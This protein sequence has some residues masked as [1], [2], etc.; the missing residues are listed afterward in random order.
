VRVTFWEDLSI[1]ASCPHDLWADD[2]P[3]AFGDR[4]CARCETKVRVVLTAAAFK[5]TANHVVPGTFPEID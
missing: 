4:L 2:G 1:I 5:T 3:D